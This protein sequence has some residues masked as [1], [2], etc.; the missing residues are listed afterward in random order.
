MLINNILM[1][2]AIIQMIKND[3]CM[4]KIIKPTLCYKKVFL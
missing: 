1:A 2:R 4:F 3:T